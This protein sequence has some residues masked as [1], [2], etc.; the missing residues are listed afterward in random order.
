MVYNSE[1]LL[2]WEMRRIPTFFYI[3]PLTKSQRMH[4]VDGFTILVICNSRMSQIYA[5]N[6]SKR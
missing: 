1:T 6:Y 4:P 3:T 2:K 5:L